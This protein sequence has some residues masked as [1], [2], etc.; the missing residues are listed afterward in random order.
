MAHKHGEVLGIS[1]L[2]LQESALRLLLTLFGRDLGCGLS[3]VGLGS[4]CYSL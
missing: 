1:C 2:V 4:L 3:M